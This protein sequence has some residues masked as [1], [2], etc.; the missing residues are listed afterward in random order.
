M[1]KNYEIHNHKARLAEEYIS[2]LADD[3]PKEHEAYEYI[4]EALLNV[5]I[6]RYSTWYCPRCNEN[7][8]D[9]GTVCE[10]CNA[11]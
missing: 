9:F 11:L 4:V 10:D 6:P 5:Y 2:K 1:S 7:L 8:V 3:V